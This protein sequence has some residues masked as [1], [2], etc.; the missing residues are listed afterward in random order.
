MSKFRTK[1]SSCCI[2]Y[3][4]KKIE[5][6]FNSFQIRHEVVAMQYLSLHLIT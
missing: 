1:V 4:G 2:L 6:S 5:Y 3:W